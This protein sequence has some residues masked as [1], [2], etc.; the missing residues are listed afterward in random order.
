MV[1]EIISSIL[2]V[3]G[4]LILAYLSSKYIGKMNL[5][6]AN[7]KHMQIIERVFINQDKTLMIVKIFQ[8]YYVVSSTNQSI[9]LLFELSLEEVEE[10][11]IS[12]QSVEAFSFKTILDK[13]KKSEEM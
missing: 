3:I 9:S 1:P 4:V 11:N 2:I 6:Q 13:I 7:S 12:N 8:K 5:K 10:L